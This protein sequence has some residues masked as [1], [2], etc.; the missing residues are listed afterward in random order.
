MDVFL[1]LLTSMGFKKEIVE[2]IRA[3]SLEPTDLEIKDKKKVL[4]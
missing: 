3:K 1:A 4:I 2:D